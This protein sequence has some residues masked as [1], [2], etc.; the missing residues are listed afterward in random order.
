MPDEVPISDLPTLDGLF[1]EA[2]A[3]IIWGEDPAEVRCFLTANGVPGAV[4]DA[5]LKEFVLER[6][7]EIRSMGIGNL[8]IGLPL[9]VVA[10]VLGYLMLPHSVNSSGAKGITVLLLCMLYGIWKLVAGI[11]YLVRPQSEHKSIPD[12]IDSDPVG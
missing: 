3:D 11:F 8:I 10:G 4:A 5:K 12:I 7:R 6:N 2:R 9:T 1:T